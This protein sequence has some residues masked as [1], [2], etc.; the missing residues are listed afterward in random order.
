MPRELKKRGRRGEE[1]KRKLEEEEGL[2]EDFAQTKRQRTEDGDG[3]GDE[4]GGQQDFVA[5]PQDGAFPNGGYQDGESHGGPPEMVFFGML[6]EE[7]QEYFK[8]ADEMLEMNNFADAEERSLFLAN[9]YRE[10]NGKELKIANSQSCSRLMERLIQLSTAAQLKTLFQK[11][12]GN[13]MHLF[14]HRFA[15]HCCEKLFIQAAPAVTQEL[16]HP[17]KPE[18]QTT[19]DGEIY[20][21]M[22][23]LFLFTLGEME[24]NVGFLMTDRFASHTLRVLL[25]V[26]AGEPLSDSTNKSLMQSKKKEHVT[27]NSNGNDKEDG[28]TEAKEDRR[29]VP[30]SFTEALEK[31]MTASVSGLDTTSLR[32]LATH[33]LGNP[34]LQLLMRI[35]LT[36]FGKSKAKDQNSIFRTLLPDDPITPECDSASFITGLLFDPIG[37]H[38]IECIIEHAP[39][40]MFKSLY[41][42]LLKERLASLARNEIA[43]Y[44]VC[45][46]LERLSKDDLMEA[47]EQI[48]PQI[49]SLLERNRFA[50]IKTLITRCAVREIDSQ[51]IAV[52]LSEAYNGPEGFDIVKLLKPDTDEPAANGNAPAPE[53]MPAHIAEERANPHT[54]KLQGSLL[55]QTMI[56]VPGS[57][58]ALILESLAALPPSTL[59]KMACDTMI[60]RTLQA[61][62][63]SQNASIISRRKLIQQFF[64]HIGEMALDRCASRVVDA[65]WEGTHGLAFIR[66]RI[67][68]EL[69]E[70]EAALRD[71]PCGRAVWKNWKMDLYKRR[72]GD[73]VKQ[74]KNK[75]SNDGFQS[76]SEQ[77]AGG[78]KK[79]AIQLARERHA[80]NKTRSLQAREKAATAGSRPA[81]TSNS[82]KHASGA[83]AITSTKL[84]NSIQ[85]LVIPFIRSADEDAATKHTGHGLQVP[86]QG[87]RTAL[88]EHHPPQKLKSLFD[89]QLPEDAQGKKGL[90]DIVDKL[91]K[92]SVNTWDQGFMDKLY[93]STNAVGVVSELLLAVLNTNLHVYQVSP[94]LTLVEKQTS[95]ALAALYG[96]GGAHGGG[97]SQ[98]G[99]S[100]SNATSI[101]I[102]RNTLHPETKKDGINGRRFTLFTSAHGHYS[103]EKA[104]QM[105]GFGSSAV[106]G[107]AVDEQGR[108]LPDALDAAVQKSKD[109]GEVPFYVNATAGTTV[110]G[111]YDPIGPI[112]DVCEKH[113][114]WLHIDGSWG[115]PVI[116][117]ATHKHKLH[118]IERADS[119]GVTPHKMLSVPMTCSFLL[120]KDMRQFQRAMTLPA[121]YLFHSPSE[122]DASAADASTPSTADAKIRPEAEIYDLADLTPQCGRRGD[123]LKLALS[124]IYYG[125]SGFEK[126]ID[127][128]FS[129]A[130]TLASLVEKTDRFT[131]V[132]ENPPPCWQVCFYYNKQDD[133]TRNSKTTE[134]IAQKLIPRGFMVDYSPG[135]DGKFFRVV[136]NSQTRKGTLEGLVK[137][138]EEVSKEVQL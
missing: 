126:S 2:H 132:S 9:V 136:V 31:L 51:A 38:L 48:C 84:L 21:S 100:A 98:P 106:I 120:G 123:A 114:L 121:G 60:C 107:V 95:K 82:S 20:V 112:A 110:L 117:S 14:Q 101:A 79:S 23:N 137:A 122:D 97:I 71:N 92:Y 87:P 83:N 54:I 91:L 115:G 119:I 124:W 27:V 94:A 77:A 16:L 73:W 72:R 34:A 96:F 13:F 35:E 81:G 63:T 135:E 15:S 17:P 102:A 116:F 32:A 133:A 130:S 86:G 131:L 93:A 65:I 57:L 113:K 105:F 76:F 3:E 128:A 125:S 104:A 41:R 62:M 18:D 24:G 8:R 99:G 45:K 74:S 37:S 103:L 88:V 42:G 89:V 61:A 39:G 10:A 4:A 50:V 43:C 22:E 52:Q 90:L 58:S 108:M 12:S 29:P 111:S 80:A 7:E 85:D 138:I 25:L 129:A 30:K 28:T 19:A 64:G 5:L 56:L 53:G 36:H 68:E 127:D 69:N 78:E 40:K 49:P 118:G 109:A 6:D 46:V 33:Q 75:A 47:H 66:E 11:F 44:V 70:N 1:K 26:L 55:A 59:Q 67:A 134:R